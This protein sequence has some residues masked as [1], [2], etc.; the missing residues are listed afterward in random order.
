[1]ELYKALGMGPG[2]VAAFV[3]AGGK[4]GAILRLASELKAVGT[5]VLAAPTTKMFLREADRIG[6][7]LTGEDEATLRRE[8]ADTLAREG[9]AVAGSALLS[10]ERVGGVEPAWVPNLAPESGV[11]LVEADGS[12]RRPLKGTAEHEPALPD[13]ATLVVA[14][15]GTSALGEP[16]S[17]ALVHRPERFSGITGVRPGQT[18]TPRS[19]ALAL[20]AGLEKAPTNARRAVLLAGVEP[21]PRM[22]ASSGVARELWRHGIG[23]VVLTSLPREQPGR[24][25]PL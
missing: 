9:A 6:P 17:E 7:V 3:G 23:K 8:I 20:L 4:S 5:P 25:W 16:L 2:D 24:I 10:G 11:T 14:V 18:I 21:G 19:V 12:R 13:G 15:A 1:L 22:A